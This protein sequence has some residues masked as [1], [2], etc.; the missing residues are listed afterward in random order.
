[1]FARRKRTWQAKGMVCDK[2]GLDLTAYRECR[3]VTLRCPNCG[4]VYPL[5]AFVPEMDDEFEE[6]MGFVPMDRI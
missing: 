2:C 4:T 3:E 1:M 6:E 5:T